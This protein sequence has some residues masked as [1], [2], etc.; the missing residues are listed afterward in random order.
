M[1]VRVRFRHTVGIHCQDNAVVS[2]NI[3][4]QSMEA[5]LLTF[6]IQNTYFIEIQFRSVTCYYIIIQLIHLYFMFCTHT[7]RY[8][9]DLS[10]LALKTVA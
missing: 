9:W 10:E 3:F 8:H 2:L 7:E 5:H 6:K 4:D 1:I